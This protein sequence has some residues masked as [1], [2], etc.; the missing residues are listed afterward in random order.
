MAHY[1]SVTDRPQ[2]CF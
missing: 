2:S 1:V